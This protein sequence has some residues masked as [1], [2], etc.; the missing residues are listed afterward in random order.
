MSKSDRKKAP[1]FEVFLARVLERRGWKVK[2][3]PKRKQVGLGAKA[4]S[5]VVGA[6]IGWVLPGLLRGPQAETLLQT[7]GQACMVAAQQCRP[8]EVDEMVDEVPG[9]PYSIRC[10]KCGSVAWLHVDELGASVHEAMSMGR[11]FKEGQWL[12]PK[13][14]V[15]EHTEA[16][17]TAADPSPST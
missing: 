1:L 2:L 12:C 15:N 10:S 6:A 9:E 11:E 14:L 8:S 7:M 13:C 4:A 17:A 16:P 5:G 3:L